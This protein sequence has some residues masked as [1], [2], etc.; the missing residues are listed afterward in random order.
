METSALQELD[1]IER[2][3]LR[4]T[5]YDWL[6]Y[7][8]QVRLT[9]ETLVEKGRSEGSGGCGFQQQIKDKYRHSN[10]NLESGLN[11]SGQASILVH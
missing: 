7:A 6:C 11:P 8:G 4:P 1:L 5:C 10:G 9:C 3:L 2:S